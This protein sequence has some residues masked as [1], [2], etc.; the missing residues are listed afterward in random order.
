MASSNSKKH[1]VSEGSVGGQSS[2]KSEQVFDSIFNDSNLL[3]AS[4]NVNGK[5]RELNETTMEYVDLPR[6]EL[7]N[8]PFWEFP[9][10]TSDEQTS[11]QRN[12]DCAADGERIKHEAEIV[13]TESKQANIQG[14]F[15]PVTNASGEVIRI[16]FSAIDITEQQQQISELEEELERIED[17]IEAASHDLKSPISAVEGRLDL[18]LQTGDLEHVEKAAEV[19]Q[20]VAD[21]RSNLV[22]ILRSDGVVAETEIID[23]E[24][25][26]ETVWGTVDPPESAS[27][28]VERDAQ[29][30]ADRT[31]LRR[32]LGNLVRNSVE[33][34]PDDVTVRIGEL[35]SGFF[36][37]DSGPGI[38]PEFRD[39][40]FSSGF[41]SKVAKDDTGIGMASV[42]QIASA[43]GWDVRIYDAEALDGVRFE[44][45][46]DS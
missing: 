15:R 24:P 31:A 40:V 18:A 38:D 5:V 34:G 20:R 43:H 7:L 21:R 22:T 6:R 39:R 16:V 11:V 17:L 26:V 1:D 9:W 8:K 4:L 32:L 35:D 44:I 46:D 2:S 45:V 41:S 10:W 13:V 3:V 19:I 42:R 37:E 29:I 28:T 25:F 33:H 36:Y 12:I 27:V 30:E 23:L 14:E